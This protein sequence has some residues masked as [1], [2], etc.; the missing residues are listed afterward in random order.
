[1]RQYIEAIQADVRKRMI[2]PHRQ[3]VIQISQELGIHQATLY[4]WGKI[5]RLQGEV[6]P[7][8]EKDLEGWAA[9]DKFTV[10]VESAGFNATELCAYCREL[11]FISSTGRPLAAVGPGCQCGADHG[12]AAGPKEETPAGTERN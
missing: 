1:M 8:L 12:G 2:P 7:A 5:W 4:N 6:V 9:A 3:S 11:G 10:L